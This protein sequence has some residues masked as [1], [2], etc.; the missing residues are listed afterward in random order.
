MASET[1][2][3]PLPDRTRETVDCETPASWATSV[4]VTRAIRPSHHAGSARAGYPWVIRST[5]IRMTTCLRLFTASVAG[6]A[7]GVG[8]A[9]SGTTTT[10]LEQTASVARAAS[11]IER[12]APAARPTVVVQDT[13]ACT[14]GAP[15]ARV[16]LDGAP[17]GARVVR[18]CGA[19]DA[20][21]AVLSAAAPGDTTVYG[22]G[23]AVRAA[24]TEVAAAHPG[25]RFVA[26]P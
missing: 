6:V 12:A 8:A 25:Q 24:L 18:V 14:S 20:L 11:V 9:V 19:G 2:P 4:E 1:R 15:A 22:S 5:L 21:G 7:L 16:G 17:R 23:P 10:P 3:A 13:A 26:L